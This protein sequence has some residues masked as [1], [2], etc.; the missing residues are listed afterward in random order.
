MPLIHTEA[1][2]IMIDNYY[3]ALA[4]TDAPVFVRTMANSSTKILVIW[5]EVPLIDQN[6]LIT[7]Y[8]VLYEPLGTFNDPMTIRSTT[9]NVTSATQLSTLLINLQEFV[10]YRIAVRAYTSIGPGPYSDD[11]LETTLEDRPGSPPSNITVYLISSTSIEV[12]W[13]EVPP[14]DQNGIIIRYEITCEA[15][16]APGRDINLETLTLLQ[17]TPNNNTYFSPLESFTT[18][19]IA[20]R[21]FTVVGAGPYS[22][23][24]LITTPE[25]GE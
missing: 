25:E 6:G 19:S 5:N 10:T 21:A 20:V 12:V 1:I 4:P 23:P 2:M 24:K 13:S 15:M 11:V 18:Y 22:L 9:V 14:I 16:E 7:A 17:Y 8:E 3:D